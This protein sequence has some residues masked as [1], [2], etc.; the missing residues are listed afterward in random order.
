MSEVITQ[1]AQHFGRGSVTY[2]VS[3]MRDQLLAHF[4]VQSGPI[5]VL[6]TSLQDQSIFM[7][8]LELETASSQEDAALLNLAWSLPSISLARNAASGEVQARFLLPLGGEG[9]KIPTFDMALNILLK[10]ADIIRTAL[11]MVRDGATTEDAL[12]RAGAVQGSRSANDAPTRGGTTAEV[13]DAEGVVEKATRLWAEIQQAEDGIQFAREHLA[14]YDEPLLNT[15]FEWSSAAHQQGEDEVADALA[16]LVHT[17]LFLRLEEQLTRPAEH[18]LAQQLFAAETRDAVASVASVWPEVLTRYALNVISQRG[19]SHLPEQM[20]KNDSQLG[21]LL[22]WLR[23]IREQDSR[24]AAALDLSAECVTRGE[25]WEVA[26][27]NDLLHDADARTELLTLAYLAD[28]RGESVLAS[29]YRE[30]ESWL[31]ESQ[32]MFFS[33][34]SAPGA[35][36]FPPDVNMSTVQE[37]VALVQQIPLDPAG[38]AVFLRSNLERFTQPVLSFLGFV[39]AQDPLQVAPGLY[40]VLNEVW[41]VKLEREKAALAPQI[42][43]LLEEVERPDSP[44]SISSLSERRDLCL[45]LLTQ[46]ERAKQPSLW[47]SLHAELGHFC[48]ELYANS[49]ERAYLEEAERAYEEAIQ[50]YEH[51]A[52]RP[53]RAQIEHALGALYLRCY[54]LTHHDGCSRAASLHYEKALNIRKREISPH[55]WGDTHGE[56]GNLFTKRYEW[57]GH[58]EDGNAA[59]RHLQDAREVYQAEGLTTEVAL[60]DFALGNLRLLR[61]KGEG[62]DEDADTAEVYLLR[63]LTEWERRGTL[64]QKVTAHHS[65]ANLLLL[66]FER[67][68]QDKHGD[69]CESHLRQSLGLLDRQHSPV[70]WAK[71]HY[72]LGT[73]SSL[74]YQRSRLEK[75]RADAERN[76]RSALEE[77]T[78]TTAPASATLPAEALARLL[79][80]GD[81]WRGAHRAYEVAIAAAENQYL[82]AQTDAERRRLMREHAPLYHRSAL[83]LLHL[84]QPAD[85]LA[86][87]EKGRA[88]IL[89]EALGLEESARALR[90]E[91]A[92]V[93]LD[94]TRAA[95][96]SAEASM[97]A[98]DS[99]MAQAHTAADR[100]RVLELREAA[101]K[102]LDASYARLRGVVNALG[103]EA[104]SLSANELTAL[105]LPPD[106]AIVSLALDRQE[107]AALILHS[108]TVR[109]IPLPAFTIEDLV[110]LMG[111]MSPEVER[112]RAAYDE[113]HCGG[114]RD[115]RAGKGDAGAIDSWTTALAEIAASG[116]NYEAGWL[117]SY[118]LAFLVVPEGKNHKATEAALAGW[119]KTVRGTAAALESR[120]WEPLSS[121]MQ[122]AVRR[123]LL[124]PSGLAS[125]LPLHA[126]APG[127]LCAAYAPSIGVWQQCQQ[128]AA[129]HRADSLLIA[130]PANNLPYAALGAGWLK[131]RSESIGRVVTTLQGAEATTD[132]LRSQA[133]THGLINFFGHAVYSWDEPMDS[134][135]RCVDGELTLAEIRRGVELNH[136]RLIVLSACETGVTDARS[137]DEFIGLPAGLLES[138]A[139]A[140][141]ASL[142]RVSDLSSTLLIDRFYELWLGNEGQ[143]TVAAALHEACL[144]LRNATKEELLPCIAKSSLPEKA[145]MAA[146]GS[147]KKKRPFSEPFD[148]MPFAAHGAVI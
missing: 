8:A 97:A 73:L 137:G 37:S 122:T 31:G 139:P 89:S 84:G 3:P 70:Q 7:Q 50:C 62:R 76:F 56:L 28:G 79:A 40:H 115:A 121:A 95:L 55:E 36:E 72:T 21:L 71:I 94:Q 132:A 27:Q 146:Y 93:K 49:G 4:Q 74:R 46:I 116:G 147:L 38:R 34:P 23:E 43:I 113:S 65:L 57:A 112:W 60:A 83:C 80:Q 41:E 25:A 26:R 109:D 111:H 104:P 144:W 85:A 140:V 101:A 75:D 32:Q 127:N 98:V 141:I 33:D 77:W 119:M 145:K 103:L 59:E 44:Q 90:G 29:R 16:S 30:I 5:A 82:A 138:G 114:R 42:G 124:V 69:A 6:I 13:G 148:W 91:E 54:E 126:T 100:R 128:R 63:A 24:R 117:H 47:A 86:V 19:M 22:E 106:V 35:Q 66:R 105:S 133:P 143:L 20:Q 107:A 15:Y 92:E 131:A 67:G 142:W 125:L 48:R 135:L 118:A 96:S 123:V 81:D 64:L 87:L 136:S 108:G 78:P 17:I 134:A 99:L 45:E 9:L 68:G 39:L 110:E 53:R 14:E 12:R 51:D 18:T 11:R 1:L 120:L 52:A 58:E 102:D 10:G 61:Y 130:T 129:G 88:R 2:A